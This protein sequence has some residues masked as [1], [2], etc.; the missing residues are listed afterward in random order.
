M[1]RRHELTDAQW[2]E[3]APL[4]PPTKPKTGKPN[5]D[6][7]TLVN[8]ILWKLRTG[9]PWR[10]VPERYGPWSTVYSRFWRSKRSSGGPTRAGGS[11]GTSTSST[12]Q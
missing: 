7:R 4:L 2:A 1:T 5:H 11:I 9:A 8:G 12:G 10:D 3:L 6:H